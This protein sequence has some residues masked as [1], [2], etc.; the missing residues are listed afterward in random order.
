MEPAPPRAPSPASVD[1]HPKITLL[2]ILGYVGIAAGLFGTFAA[3]AETGGDPRTTVLVTS[4]ALSAVFLFAGALI[5]VD[6]PDRLARMRSVC[7]FA[8]V[9]AFAVFLGV[10]IEPSDR[11]G[12]ALVTGLA[13]LYGLLLWALSPRTLQQLAFSVFAIATVAILIAFPDLGFAFGPPD[14][15]GAGLVLWLGGA[16]WFALGFLGLVRPPRSAMVIGMVFGLEGLSLLAQDNAEVAA[17]LILASSALCLYL[18]GSIG[19]RAVT[20]VAVVGLSIGTIA[21]LVALEIEGTGPGLVALFV[22]V[23]LLGVGVWTARTTGPGP[24]AAFGPLTSPFGRTKVATR[25]Q[26]PPPPEEDDR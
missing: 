24:R 18:G 25:S 17:V 22:G 6:A 9:V 16:V 23:V 7:W 13:A 19:D 3:L 1:P 21:L 15:S 14:V 2:E 12:F 11:G 4:L 26:V 8:S 20:G 10:A 5:G